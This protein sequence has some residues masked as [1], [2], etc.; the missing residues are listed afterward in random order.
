VTYPSLLPSN[1]SE[2]ATALSETGAARY[3]LPAELVASVWSPADCPV[4]I[5]PYLAWALSVDLWDDAWPETL[6]REACRRALELHRLKTTVAGIKEHVALTGSKVLRVVRPPARGYSY[7]AM[8]PEQKAAW[9]EGLPQIRIYPF[10]RRQIGV[11]SRMFFSGPGGRS[12]HSTRQVALS[13]DWTYTSLGFPQPQIVTVSR[14]ITGFH[15]T[16]RGLNLFGRRAAYYDR[17]VERDINYDI[18]SFGGTIERAYISRTTK[19]PFLKAGGFS[20]FMSASRG[21][22]GVITLALNDEAGEFAIT[23]S[24]RPVDVRPQRVYQAR[25]APTA[26]AFMGRFRNNTFMKTSFGPLMIYDKVS[27][28]DPARMGARRKTRS[29]HGHG[30][31]GIAPYTSEIL[32]RVPMTRLRSR[33]ARFHKVGFLKSANMTPLDRAI[34]AVRVSKAFRDTVL[35]DTTTYRSV[36]LGAGL[37]LGSF[38]LGELKEVV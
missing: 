4:H 7:A 35:I 10:Y 16:S 19:R 14:G 9:L 27:L 26:R 34:E 30:R 18:D 37:K 24:V 36:T 3:P 15:R 21:A 5:L 20:H 33:R 29:Y 22:S 2:W 11:K 25:T 28:H 6:K 12:F 38:R 31:L 23:P 17:G 32:I 1:R 13:A 8:T